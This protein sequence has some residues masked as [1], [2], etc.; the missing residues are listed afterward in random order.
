VNSC[1]DRSGPELVAPEAVNRIRRKANQGGTDVDIRLH[2]LESFQ[3]RGS[4]GQ[5]YKVFGYERLARDESV[6]SAPE[7][8]EP[9]GTHEYRLSDGAFVEALDDGS[10]RIHGSGVAL[11][12][13]DTGA[14]PAAGAAAPAKKRAARKR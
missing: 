8:W 12:R 1:K 3:A 14:M 13:E 2:L 7:R 4:D 11:A 5:T 10:M 9:T 6:P